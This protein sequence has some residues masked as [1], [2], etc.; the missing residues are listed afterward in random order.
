MQTPRHSLIVDITISMFLQA[1]NDL[2]LS[3][4][5]NIATKASKVGFTHDRKISG[6]KTTIKVRTPHCRKELQSFCIVL[7][8]MQQILHLHIN[9]ASAT[10]AALWSCTCPALGH[11][12]DTDAAVAA[13]S[14]RP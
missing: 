3:V 13:L 2:K 14:T 4:S 9:G 12:G 6:K 1:R 7:N 5:H 10:M 8:T 11:P